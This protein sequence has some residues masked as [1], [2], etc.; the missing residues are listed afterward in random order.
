MTNGTKLTLPIE[1]G[2]SYLRR[3]NCVVKALRRDNCGV[4]WMTEDKAVFAS[5]GKVNL[6]R[7]CPGDLVADYPEQPAWNTA[8]VPPK[9]HIHAAS[10][11]L[12]AQDAAESD[13][14]WKLWEHRH[15]ASAGFQDCRNHPSW[16]YDYVYRRKPKTIRIGTI[17]VPE[18]L[19]AVPSPGT[20][21]HVVNLS[22][23]TG[24]SHITWEVGEYAVQDR[25]LA[26]GLLHTTREAAE[27]HAKALLSFTEV[28]S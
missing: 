5:N 21:M 9:G 2:K 23:S 3:D 14:P 19:R 15:I 7:D 17:D 18:P 16:L 25:L 22:A 8:V 11:A 10:M 28:Q 27:Q 24:S 26:R 20:V 1:V 6:H 13:A 4:I 12:Y